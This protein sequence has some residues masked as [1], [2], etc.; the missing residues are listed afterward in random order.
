M[1]WFSGF[2]GCGVR[3]VGCVVRCTVCKLQ[4][5]VS[6]APNVGAEDKTCL[7]VLSGLDW[8][9]IVR[10]GPVSACCNGS[11]PDPH[12]RSHERHIQ[13]TTSP[14]VAHTSPTVGDFHQK[15]HPLSSR[16]NFICFLNPGAPLPWEAS[17]LNNSDAR[18]T[19][20]T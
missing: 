13:T 7:S 16:D 5:T 11:N 4:P 18:V 3:V 8:L 15:Q 6:S 2:V 1:V 9:W 19:C 14:S 17:I 20:I 10:G 12:K